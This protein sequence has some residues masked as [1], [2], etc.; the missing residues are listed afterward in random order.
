MA[1]IGELAVNIVAKDK[2][3]RGLRNARQGFRK[4]TTVIFAATAAMTA[5]GIVVGRGISRLDRLAKTAKRIGADVGKLGG[6]QFAGELAGVAPRTL[7]MALQRMVRRL[8]EAALGTGEAVKAL[9]T[10]NLSAE[11]LN[12]LSPHK[13]FLAITRAMQGMSRQQQ[14]PLIFKFFDSE[15]VALVNLMDQGADALNRLIL[16]GERLKGLDAIGISGVEDMANELT[17][18]K[19][20]M[21]GLTNQLT[22][23]MGHLSK[24]ALSRRGAEILDLFFRV[25]PFDLSAGA[26]FLGRATEPPPF[27]GITTP[28]ERAGFTFPETVTAPRGRVGIAGRPGTR[29]VMSM[30]KKIDE[31]TAVAA[32]DK[33]FHKV[34]VTRAF[35]GKFGQSGLPEGIDPSVLRNQKF[36]D[37]ELKA[38][39]KRGRERK[40]IASRDLPERK[41]DTTL[42]AKETGTAEAFTALRR[43]L[44]S[45]IPKQQLMEAKKTNRHLR[46]L[47]QRAEMLDEPAVA[48]PGLA[49]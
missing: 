28:A 35:P 32:F 40:L 49:D 34:V 19:T 18:A 37:E 47:V 38:F 2:S 8:G 30:I 22:I 45:P 36:F 15:G 48:A 14:L 16:E 9:N 43:N 1:T 41:I 23:F 39:I 11:R 21:E 13:Q 25:G 31:E 7:D 12:K 3:S 29:E 24:L 10:L 42:V 33:F 27:A 5:F 6:L 4:F 20:Q 17:R 26:K 44:R 46:R